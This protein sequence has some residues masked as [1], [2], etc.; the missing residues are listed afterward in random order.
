VFGHWEL[1][2]I[3][4]RKS[5]LFSGSNAEMR[6]AWREELMEQLA[7]NI[8]CGYQR[9]GPPASE[10][11]CLA[12]IALA[13]SGRA[14]L[15]MQALQWLAS[16][17]ND[18]GS[19]GPSEAQKTPGWPTALALVADVYTC[20]AIGNDIL[21]L[22]G[23]SSNHCAVSPLERAKA[24]QWLVDA[25][26]SPTPKTSDVDVKSIIGHDA[27]LVGWPWVMG[28]H[29]WVEPTALDVMALKANGRGEH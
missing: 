28:T 10:P 8:P 15:S 3:R 2:V 17:Q 18:D 12:A 11:T 9:Q 20:H 4:P 14:E 22:C 23:Q 5:Y 26:P 27:T 19:V 6:M 1:V 25:M 24:M 29:S 7:A 13:Q 21:G 16:I